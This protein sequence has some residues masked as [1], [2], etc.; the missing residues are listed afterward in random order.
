M[1]V[2]PPIIYSLV[3]RKKGN[4]HK[5]HNLNNSIDQL[6]RSQPAKYQIKIQGRHNETWSDWMDDLEI[7]IVRL[8][9]GASITVLTGNVKDQAGLH[10]LLNRIRDLSIPLISVQF[11][12]PNYFKKE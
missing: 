2:L 1:R 12:N 10:G 5:M 7:N 4:N 8:G 3:E 11:L 9:K 6:R